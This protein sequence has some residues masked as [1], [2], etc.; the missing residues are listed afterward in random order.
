[1]RETIVGADPAVV[2]TQ[3]VDRRRTHV[4]GRVVVVGPNGR[5][6]PR[7]MAVRRHVEVL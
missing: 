3:F 2:A 1:M 6:G 7:T 5:I 4:A